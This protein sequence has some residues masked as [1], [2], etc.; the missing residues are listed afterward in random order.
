[1][2]K[3]LFA[4]FF[5]LPSA[6]AY[7]EFITNA[8]GGRISLLKNVP[9]NDSVIIQATPK[10]L[11]NKIFKTTSRQHNGKLLLTGCGLI[12]DP[13]LKIIWKEFGYDTF[14]Y[15]LNEVRSDDPNDPRNKEP[16]P[17]ALPVKPDW[18]APRKWQAPDLPNAPQTD[19]WG[20]VY[21]QQEQRF[22]QKQQ[23][24]YERPIKD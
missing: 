14:T 7:E 19:H 3:L 15:G 13:F 16:L 4:L 1:M 23:M 9:C 17:L 10:E 6:H 8:D 5:V 11:R 2:R 22:Q 21:K 24:T 18:N 20:N 12:D